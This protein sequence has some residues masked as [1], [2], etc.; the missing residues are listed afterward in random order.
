MLHAFSD[1][2][3]EA[4][5]VVGWAIIGLKKNDTGLDEEQ[6]IEHIIANLAHDLPFMNSEAIEYLQLAI[7]VATLEKLRPGRDYLLRPLAPGQVVPAGLLQ[8]ATEVV[9]GSL[10]PVN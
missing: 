9:A 6:F 5:D 10:S 8:V 7:N 3:L 4:L 1:A 2:H